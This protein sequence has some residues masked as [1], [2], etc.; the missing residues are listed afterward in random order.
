MTEVGKGG[1][2]PRQ[3]AQLVDV[4]GLLDEVR[5]RPGMWVR[6][7][8]LL[9]LECM[10]FGYGVALEIHGAEEDF[11]FRQLGPFSSW[12]WPRLGMAHGSPLGWAAEIERAAK[13]ADR[14]ALELFFDL[15]DEFRADSSPGG[16]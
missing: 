7:G 14:P 4:Y 10:L 3:L 2:R 13:D 16:R 8:S 9:E 1:R 15:L 12:L 6:R 5:L 11:V